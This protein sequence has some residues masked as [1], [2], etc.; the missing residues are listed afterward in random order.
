[1]LNLDALRKEHPLNLSFRN[2]CSTALEANIVQLLVIRTSLTLGKPKRKR[3]LNENEDK[4]NSAADFRL[5][6]HPYSIH[7]A[8]MRY[9]P[10]RSAV[11]WIYREHR[12]V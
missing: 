7:V 4:W 8:T 3:G 11:A 6:S 9:P 10:S 12:H 5:S 1:M 2:Q